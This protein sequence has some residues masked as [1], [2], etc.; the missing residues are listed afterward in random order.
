MW[1]GG[2]IAKLRAAGVHGPALSWFQSY[3]SDRQQRTR[4]AR[5]VSDSR[6]LLAGVP[7]GAILSPLLF[8]LYVNDIVDATPASVNLF[9]DETSSFVVASNPSDL[10][11]KLQAVVDSLSTWF[12]KW[13][14]SVNIEKSA[15]LALRQPRSKSPDVPIFL[16]GSEYP[17]YARIA[18]LVSLLPTV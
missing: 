12:D 8:I 14:L 7:Q 18:T 3:L 10:R 4:V 9:A 13:L 1:H 15:V 17:R 11:A 5:A 16:H 6:S 2:L